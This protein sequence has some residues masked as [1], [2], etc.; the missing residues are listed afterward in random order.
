M[1]AIQPRHIKQYLVKRG[2]TAKVRANREKALFSHI[3]NFAREPNL[4]E[5]NAKRN[6]G[7]TPHK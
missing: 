2:E 1:D 7:V 5:R 6:P 4:T 3:F